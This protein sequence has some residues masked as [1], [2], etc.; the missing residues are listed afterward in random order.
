M[1]NPEQFKKHETDEGGNIESAR[2][3]YD[4]LTE[5]EPFDKKKAKVNVE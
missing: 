1:G 4:I 3:E 2:T 5:V